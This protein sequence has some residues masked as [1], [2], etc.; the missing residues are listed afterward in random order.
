MKIVEIFENLKKEIEDLVGKGTS[1]ASCSKQAHDKLDDLN[2]KTSVDIAECLNKAQ[3]QAEEIKSKVEGLMTGANVLAV[4]VAKRMETCVKNFGEDAAGL[5]TCLQSE[6]ATIK[7]LLNQMKETITET[8]NVSEELSQEISV[9]LGSC[10]D[11]ARQNAF[12][13]SNKVLNGVKNCMEEL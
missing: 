6:V 9:Q 5:S 7:E 3:K 2:E 13:T 4:D 11:N 12:N 8:I 1:K 10:M